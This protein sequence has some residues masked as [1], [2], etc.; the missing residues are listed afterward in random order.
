VASFIDSLKGTDAAVEV[1]IGQGRLLTLKR[2]ITGGQGTAV[3]AVGDPTV[4]EFEVLPNPRMIRLIGRRAGVTDMSITAADGETFSFEVHVVYD[5]ELLR[6]Q[7]RQIFPD[8]R[9]RLAQLREHLVIEGEARSPAQVTH[10]LATAQAF[11]ASVSPQTKVQAQGTDRGGSG[12]RGSPYARGGRS[13]PRDAGEGDDAASQPPGEVEGRPQAAAPEE[14]GDVQAEAKYP[15]PQIINL[16]RVPGL[17]QVLLQVRVA[18]L[19]RTG[20]REIG[21]D[22]M[23]ID[24]THGTVGGTQIGGAAVSALG[25]VLG[26]SGLVSN[27]TVGTS[28]NS[29]GYGIFPSADFEVVL[30]AL[31]RNSLLRI[32]AEPNLV[33]MSGQQA[34]FLAGGQIPVPVPQSGLSNA[35]TIEWKD[36]GVQLVFVPYVQEDET[37]RLV[38]EPEVSTIDDALGTVIL[39]TAVPGINTRRVKTTVELREGQTLALAGLLQVTLDGGTSR[40]PLLGDLPYIGP[41]F[42]NTDHKRVEKELLVLVTPCLVSPMEPCDVPALPG[43]QI[44]DPNDLEFYL[45]NRIEGRTGRN[46]RSTTHWDDP[47]GLRRLMRLETRYV[48]GPVGYSN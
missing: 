19:N 16:I 20:A 29:T 25:N 39:G 44:E 13:T 2:D 42:S 32:L 6:A 45:L 30:R 21:A 38:V 37:I 10:I 27:A 23:V 33:A 1:L 22:L 48:S 41:L 15:A 46:F 3:V 36:F 17:H 40:I 9:L 43:D 35:I 7:L 14:G 34:S 31:R 5:M 18:E 4:I 47:L 12:G 28:S 26:L 24:P 11:L 8:A